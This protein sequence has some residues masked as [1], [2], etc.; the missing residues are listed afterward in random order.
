MSW[1][2]IELWNQAYV[3]DI[4]SVL[5]LNCAIR[6]MNLAGEEMKDN[7]EKVIYKCMR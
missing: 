4:C 2:I 7:G 5:M 3:D 6:H 1:L